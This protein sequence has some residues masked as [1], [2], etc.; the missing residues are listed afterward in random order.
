LNPCYP[1][2]LE[3]SGD[4]SSS[5]IWSRKAAGLLRGRMLGHD[6]LG[7]PEELS[8][9]FTEWLKRHDLHGMKS[10]FD[11]STFDAMGLALSRDLQALVGPLTKVAYAPL[12][13]NHRGIRGSLLRLIRSTFRRGR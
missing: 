12:S 4:Y 2:N 1:K 10:G 6:E 11:V 9:R 7:L 8:S 13:A 3:V 5:G